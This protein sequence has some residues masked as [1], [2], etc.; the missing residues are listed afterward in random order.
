MNKLLYAVLVLSLLLVACGGDNEPVSEPMETATIP[1]PT[2][3]SVVAQIY[4][5]KNS[6]NRGGGW[7]CRVD[8]F[9]AIVRNSTTL[10]Q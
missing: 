9:A 7:E 1:P 8:A 2:A 4:V 5:P 6:L 10:C 3:T